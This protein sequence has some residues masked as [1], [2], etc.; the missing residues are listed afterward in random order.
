LR[1]A[2]AAEAAGAANEDAGRVRENGLTGGV[3]GLGVDR[4][5]RAFALVVDA[6][7][8]PAGGQRA[9]RRDR[10]GDLEALL[11]VQE[12]DG[13]DLDV[14]GQ[15]HQ[16]RESGDDGERRYHLEVALE[17]ERQLLGADAEG[18]E[19]DVALFVVE[20]GRRQLQADDVR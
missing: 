1:S 2:V 16:R 6:G 19:H 4:D 12:H 7:H 15:A 9:A 20:G 8:S 17:D 14:L 5:E 3:R 10:L 18:V 13:V 11:A